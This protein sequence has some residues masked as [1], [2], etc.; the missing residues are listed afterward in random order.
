[1][2]RNFIEMV[3]EGPRGKTRG[4]I[5]G[6]LSG[7]GHGNQVIDAEEEEFDCEPMRE[8]IR[9]MLIPSGNTVHLL[10]PEDLRDEV[11]EAIAAAGAWGA[12]LALRQ[13]RRVRAARFEFDFRIYSREHAARVK[14]LLAR[15]P[16]DV[17]L[18]ADPF[19]ET[20]LPGEESGGAFAPVHA[21]ELRGEGSASGPIEA[22][23]PMY[24]RWREEELIHQTR[25]E[26]LS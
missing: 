4:F 21:Y 3:I 5:E 19:Q 11:D 15:V 17:T 18:E 20:D 6:F 22:I 13:E 26:M 25:L 2:N 16:E 14:E 23:L 24:R 7:R 8:R 10:V 9:E 1:M 12:T